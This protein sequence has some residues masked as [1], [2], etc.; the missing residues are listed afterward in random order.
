MRGRSRRKES[1]QGILEYILMLAVAVSIF[2]VLANGFKRIVLTM[3]QQMACE[4][5][6]PCPGCAPPESVRNK[7]GV[8]CR[9]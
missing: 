1:G 8:S 7:L 6:A 3:W 2:S 5:A 9:G 4:I